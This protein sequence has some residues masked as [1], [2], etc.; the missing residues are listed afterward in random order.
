MFQRKPRDEEE[1]Q[2]FEG[3]SSTPPA[4]SV[5]QLLR[6]TREGHGWELRDV[7][8]ALRIRPDYLEALE[9]N[10]VEGLPGVAYATGF[11]RAYADYLGLDGNEAVRR[12]KTEKKTLA[13]KPDLSF[14]VPLTDRGIPGSG[15]FLIALLLITLAYGTWYY[16]SSGEHPRPPAVEPVPARLLPPPPQAEAP[17]PPA[18]QEAAKPA[19]GATTAPAAPAGTTSSGAIQSGTAPATAVTAP[20]TP[21]PGV[22]IVPP[23]AP[24]AQ[25][26]QPSIGAPQLAAGKPAPGTV[27]TGSAPA[28]GQPPVAAQAQTQPPTGQTPAGQT[29]PQT[30]AGA[31]P[32]VPPESAADAKGPKSYGAV[33]NPGRILVKATGYAWVQVYDGKEAILTRTLHPGDT[34]YVPAKPGLIM[35]TGNAGGLSFVVDGKELPALGPTGMVKKK[36]PLDPQRLLSGDLGED[37]PSKPKPTAPRSQAP[38]GTSPAAAPPIGAPTAAPSTGEDTPE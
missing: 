16:L 2:P 14:P 37:V 5:G 10:T 11:L 17:I 15:L 34:Y 38:A 28:A 3:S 33:D 24:P 27:A 18:V 8:A 4:G 12:F 1:E 32:A 21:A 22:T 35:R 9:R 23:A 31:V 19:D 29:L 20:S 7:A 13:S 30:A 6:Q 36:I 26:F 25:L